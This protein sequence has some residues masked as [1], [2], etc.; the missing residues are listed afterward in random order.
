MQKKTINLWDVNADKIV[1]SSLTETKN[2][3]KYLIGHLDEVVK[4]IVLVL[5]KRNG[6]V[7]NLEK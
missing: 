1:N 6:Y 3:A 5:P 2:D 7:K 4:P